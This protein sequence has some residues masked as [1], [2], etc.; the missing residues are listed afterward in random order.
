VQAGAGARPRQGSERTSKPSTHY[1]VSHGTR[2]E[3][4][5]MH[6]HEVLA[7]Q[8]AK[9]F[10]HQGEPPDD[11]RQVAQRA[12]LATTAC[13]EGQ[14]QISMHGAQWGHRPEPAPK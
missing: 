4:E 8:L 3:A 5:L 14:T 13:H 9:R 10:L 2:L 6:R 1:A 11:L 7:L 12:I